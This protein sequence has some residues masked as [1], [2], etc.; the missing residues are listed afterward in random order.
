M[1][2]CFYFFC[3]I[4]GI[5]QHNTKNLTN[6]K[7]VTNSMKRR[8]L[9]FIALIVAFLFG[10]LPLS[11]ASD[12]D[13]Q[14]I[15]GT[16]YASSITNTRVKLVGD[17]SLYV[18]QDLYLREIY[19]GPDRT[20]AIKVDFGCTLTVDQ[21]WDKTAAV[22]VRNLYLSGEGHTLITGKHFGVCIRK[23]VLSIQNT[24]ATF[25]ARYNG[26]NSDASWTQAVIAENG[27]DISVINSVATFNSASGYALSGYIYNRDFEHHLNS[28]TV[29]GEKSKV[30]F[31]ATVG[32]SQDIDNFNVKGGEVHLT[33]DHWE[34]VSAKNVNLTGGKI[35]VNKTGSSGLW[36]AIVCQKM[37]VSN[38]E[39]TINSS[40]AGIVCDGITINNATVNATGGSKNYAIYANING[41]EI[42]GDK[43][44]VNADAPYAGLYSDGNITIKCKKVWVNASTKGCY[45]VWTARKLNIDLLDVNSVYEAQS[46]Q[47]GPIYAGEGIY[48]NRAASIYCIPYTGN[49]SGTHVDV[50]YNRGSHSL[51]T[52]GGAYSYINFS[53]PTLP[54]L[55]PP[56]LSVYSD[57]TIT[58]D[59][60]SIQGYV[61]E[62]NPEI[63]FTMY[64]KLGV[65]GT[66]KIVEVYHPKSL[67]W[68]VTQ[69]LKD[70]DDKYNYWGEIS[71][72]PYKGTRKTSYAYLVLKAYPKG[73]VNR[74]W[75]VDISDIVAVI[76]TMAGETFYKEYSDVNEDNKT[77]ISD[78]VAII[79]YMAGK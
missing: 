16:V 76:N 5:K 9:A 36:H 35:Y 59:L 66:P 78:I 43:T 30:Y 12:A 2:T 54:D 47:I 72:V 21:D 63:T 1:L 14:E 74:D 28:V 68:T 17:V 37:S 49:G 57:Q 6:M 52:T 64:K 13:Y 3:Y 19:G 62:D 50:S 75:V 25:S 26:S 15:K 38:C 33:E 65:D 45:A 58:F 10:H 27:S 34:A 60:S 79:N 11:A 31:N 46:N 73:D 44:V 22:D 53:A 18:N 51:T 61:W 29:Q 55:D 70:S 71:V 8:L 24:T 56:I 48:M 7:T 20:I 32:Y 4:C 23:G 39:L 77:D 40:T 69:K 67:S 41:I 42:T